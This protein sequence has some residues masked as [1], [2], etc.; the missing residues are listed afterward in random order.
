M[1]RPSQPTD[2]SIAYGGANIRLRNSGLNALPAPDDKLYRGIAMSTRPNKVTRLA[3]YLEE[4]LLPTAC[5]LCGAIAQRTPNLCDSCR[6]D[7][8][9]LETA[10]HRCAEPL[11]LPGTCARC[12]RSP[13]PVDRTLSAFVYTGYVPHLVQQLKFAGSQPVARLLDELLCDFVLSRL[14]TRPDAIVPVPLHPKRLRSRGFNQA[15]EISRALHKKLALPL[16]TRGVER[17]GSA[18]PQTLQESAADRR[19]NV[20]EVFKV[21]ASNETYEH[22]ALVDDVMSSGATVFSL[23]AALRTHSICRIEVWTI[24]RAQHLES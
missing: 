15:L 12:Q 5:V 8:P 19:R 16:V 2:Y 4:A 9:R 17:H 22:I 1:I 10:C 11:V 3:R 7:L 21:C 13:P 14:Q 24:A 18:E 6:N 20:R 23:A